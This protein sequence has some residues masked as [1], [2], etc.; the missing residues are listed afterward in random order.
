MGMKEYSEVKSFEDLANEQEEVSVENN[1]SDNTEAAT[2][3]AAE[4]SETQNPE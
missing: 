2:E 1:T 3:T 4:V